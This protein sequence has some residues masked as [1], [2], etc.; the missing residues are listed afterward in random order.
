MVRVNFK[1][2][3]SSDNVCCVDAKM[4]TNRPNQMTNKK[5]KKEIKKK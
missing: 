1:T 2:G 3:S 4:S 5:E